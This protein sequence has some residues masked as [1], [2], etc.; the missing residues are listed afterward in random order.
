MVMSCLVVHL[1]FA[2]Q[3]GDY[4]GVLEDL[5]RMLDA[6]GAPAV[7]DCDKCVAPVAENKAA[8]DQAAAEKNAVAEKKAVAKK[9]AH[10][11]PVAAKPA[12]ACPPPSPPLPPPLSPP[13]AMWG[14]A[15]RK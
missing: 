4:K 6:E 7:P 9:K 8:A 2:P 14:I 15:V 10:K 3:E 12:P 11:D 13:D 5:S 1:H